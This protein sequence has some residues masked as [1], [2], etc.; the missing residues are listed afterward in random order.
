MARMFMVLLATHDEDGTVTQRG[1]NVDEKYA[2]DMTAHMGEPDIEQ[3][4][5]PDQSDAAVQ[6]VQALTILR[7]EETS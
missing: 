7:E 6:A 3:F 4:Y 2:T 1:W 5:A